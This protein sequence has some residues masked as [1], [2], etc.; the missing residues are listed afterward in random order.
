MCTPFREYDFETPTSSIIG[1][2]PLLARKPFGGQPDQR[3]DQRDGQWVEDVKNFTVVVWIVSSTNPFHQVQHRV[4]LNDCN[5]LWRQVARDVKNRRQEKQRP[6]DN[7]LYMLPCIDVNI[8]DS[9]D[10][11]DTKPKK[12]RR[13]EGGEDTFRISGERL[14]CRGWPRHTAA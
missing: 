10:S 9:I 2:E 3:Q 7:F 1:S 8:D 13:P 4:P 6:S 12:C 11:A 5:R 14:R